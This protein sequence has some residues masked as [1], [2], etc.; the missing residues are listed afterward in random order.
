PGADVARLAGYLFVATGL[1]QVSSPLKEPL[2]RLRDEVLTKLALGLDALPVRKAPIPFQ[3]VTAEALVFP[4][5]AASD[6]SAEERVLQHMQKYFEETWIHRPRRVLNNNAPVD[7][8]GH[9][10]LRKKLR[11]VIQ[12]LQDCAAGGIVGKYDFDRLR[13]KLGL[14]PGGAPAAAGPAP[15]G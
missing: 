1:M 6:Q 5:R 7:A 12:F 13:R 8:A 2:E 9:P 3:D 11:G 14:L 15:A 10:T 4:L